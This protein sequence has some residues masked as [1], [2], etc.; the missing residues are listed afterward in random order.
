MTY[1]AAIQDDLVKKYASGQRLK[2]IESETG[3]PMK[4]I[5]RIIHKS[6]APMRREKGKKESA[7]LGLWHNG[8]NKAQIARETGYCWLTVHKTIKKAG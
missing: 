1:S 3:V 6:G 7:I 4:T 5:I 8:L 2:I